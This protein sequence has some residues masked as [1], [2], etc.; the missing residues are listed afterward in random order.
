MRRIYWFAFA[1]LALL[2]G[3]EKTTEVSVLDVSPTEIYLSESVNTQT[4]DIS[5]SSPWTATCDAG[6]IELD[7]TTGTKGTTSL[8]VQLSGETASEWTPQATITLRN[9]DGKTADITVTY[10]DPNVIL[11]TTTDQ[12]MLDLGNSFNAY[13]IESHTYGRIRF[14]NPV[15]KIPERAFSRKTTLASIS[16]PHGVESIGN[17]AFFYC[18]AFA[19]ITI[20]NSVTSVGSL[21]FD[22]CSALTDVYYI[23]ELA[24]WCG[25]R[26]DGFT[27]NPLYYAHNLYID[28]TLVTELVIPEVVTQIKDYAFSCYDALTQATIGNS[29]TSIGDDAFSGCSALTQVAIGNSV[30][31]IGD[32]AFG[33]CTQLETV[34]CKPENPPTLGQ[35]AFFDTNLKTI[36]VPRNSVQSYKNE[37]NDYKDEIIGYDFN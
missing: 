37:W 33:N 10:D 35:S 9:E 14:Y 28:N 29:V 5:S 32:W 4:C 31:S 22:G 19:K 3:C 8:T 34:F 21:A 11:Y 36:Y 23:G 16:M 6:W 25:I 1:L 30:T 26:F 12:K 2:P 7:K 27:A 24:E 17:G 18:S 20:P 13:D 15:K